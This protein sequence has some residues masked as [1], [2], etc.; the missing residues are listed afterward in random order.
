M[1]Q[2]DELKKDEPQLWFPGAST[3]VWSLFC[4]CAGGDL[5]AVTRLIDRNPALVRAH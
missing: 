4:A 5:D 3:E 2:P 1:V